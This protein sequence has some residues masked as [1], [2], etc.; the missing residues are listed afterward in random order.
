MKG[1]ALAEAVT[2]GGNVLGSFL[3]AGTLASLRSQGSSAEVN[4]LLREALER[5][6]PAFRAVRKVLKGGS[7]V[8]PAVARL[9]GLVR[10]GVEFDRPA[11]VADLRAAIRALLATLGFVLPRHTGPGIAC[12]L[13]GKGCPTPAAR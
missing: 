3:C 11:D 10:R 8:E 13:H 5:Y 12:E 1:P 4:G 7:D 6:A 9:E 2:E